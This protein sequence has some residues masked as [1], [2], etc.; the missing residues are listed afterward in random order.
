[1]GP[2][3]RSHSLFGRHRRQ[4]LR[5]LSA[6]LIRCWT[7]FCLARPTMYYLRLLQPRDLLNFIARLPVVQSLVPQLLINFVRHS[8][9]LG[10]EGNVAKM[11]PY[12]AEIAKEPL[13]R[14]A[15]C[16]N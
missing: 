6:I 10:V 13:R 11:M 15:A 14:I 2:F 4:R 1:M 16:A 9:A 12:K 3:R 8:R 5:K 7:Q